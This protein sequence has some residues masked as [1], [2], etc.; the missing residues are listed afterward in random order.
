MSPSGANDKGGPDRSV[1][2]SVGE[3]KATNLSNG[4]IVAMRFQK[5]HYLGAETVVIDRQ[6]AYV[7]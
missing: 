7:V 6:T 1:L 5:S 4:T 2:Q 3:N